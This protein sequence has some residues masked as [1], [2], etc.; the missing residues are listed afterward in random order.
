MTTLA[1]IKPF[2][3]VEHCSA[4][5]LVRLKHRRWQLGLARGEE[6]LHHGVVPTIA[7]AAHAPHHLG[8]REQ[9]LLLDAR[10][11]AAAVAVVNE[12]R[13]RLTPPNGVV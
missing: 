13:R 9:R 10:I 4:G 5:G 2:N 3:I 7:G 11:L 12:P 8:L 6:A 1:I